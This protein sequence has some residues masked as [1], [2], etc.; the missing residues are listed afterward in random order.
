[1]PG[2][3]RA[4]GAHDRTDWDRLR[5]L[6]DAEIENLASADSDNPATLADDAWND[7]FV[8]LP[9]ADGSA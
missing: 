5:S 1:M 4:D 2:G 8:G 6:S 3:N 7:A 9:P